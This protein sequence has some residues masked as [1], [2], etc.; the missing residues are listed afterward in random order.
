M[1]LDTTVWC[2]IG[3]WFSYGPGYHSIVFPG[4][5]ETVPNEFELVEL[6]PT[7]LPADLN[8]GSMRSPECFLCI[9]R[10]KDRPPLV[11]I[12]NITRR[13]DPHRPARRPEPWLHALSGVL[14]L[15]T[16]GKG[17]TAACRYR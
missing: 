4:L 16:E 14:P 9:R 10:G 6:T 11:D 7:G 12:G 13:A 3:D 17:S 5:G 1:A 2:R 15:H 8:H